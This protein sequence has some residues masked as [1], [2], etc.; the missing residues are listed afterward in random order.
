MDDAETFQ[1]SPTE[2]WFIAHSMRARMWLD[3]H[4]LIENGELAKRGSTVVF[5]DGWGSRWI[6]QALKDG[7]TIGTGDRVLTQ[8]DVPHE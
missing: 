2:V 5:M 6:L 7:L 8:E 1:S 3:Q 4:H